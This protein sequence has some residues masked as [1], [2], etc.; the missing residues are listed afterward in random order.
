MNNDF[1]GVVSQPQTSIG[2]RTKL[3]LKLQAL[4][5]SNMAITVLGKRCNTRLSRRV[6]LVLR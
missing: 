5:S 2:Y 6:Q 1:D 4:I 3:Y